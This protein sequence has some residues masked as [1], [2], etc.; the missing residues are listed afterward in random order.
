MKTK[1]YFAQYIART[2]GWFG[3]TWAAHVRQASS[4]RSLK[5][6]ERIR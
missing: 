4:I 3:V 5:G 2:M 1:K 6:A